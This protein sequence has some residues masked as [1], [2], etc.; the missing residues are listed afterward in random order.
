MEI[1]AKSLINSWALGLFR[2]GVGEKK[3]FVYKKALG[4]GMFLLIL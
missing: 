2:Q 4:K 3:N 1:C